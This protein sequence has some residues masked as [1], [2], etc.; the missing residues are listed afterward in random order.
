MQKNDNDIVDNAVAEAG[1]YDIIRKRLSEQGSTLKIQAQQLNAE[2]LEEFG[3]VQMEAVGRTRVRT[4]NNC[5]PRDIV[6]VGEQLL[7]GYNVF[8]GLKKDTQISDV[9]ALFSLSESDGKYELI[10]SDIHKSFL[11]DQRFKGDFDELYR[12]YKEARLVK[13]TNKDGKLLAG[14]QVGERQNDLKV[15]RWSISPDGGKLDYIDNRGERDIQLPDQYDFEWVETSREDFVHGKHPHVNIL[16]TVFVETIGGDLTIKVEDNTE[17][18]LGIYSEPVDEAN[19]SL[20]DASVKYAKVGHLI[21]LGITPYKE[22]NTRYFVFNSLSEKVD[23][24][25]AI[26]LSCIQ[27]PEDHG[28]IFPGGY[29]LESG[30]TKS[31]PGDIDGLRFK[32]MI[33][34]PNGEDVL[35]VFYEETEGK[36]AL[37]SYNLIT[38]SLQN[39]IFSNGYALYQNGTLIIFSSEEESTRV[40]PMQIWQTSY[41]SAEFASQQPEST[42]ELGKIGNSELVRGISD[43]YSIQQMIESTEISMRHYEELNETTKRIFDTHYWLEDERNTAIAGTLKEVSKTAELVIDEFEKVQ[44]IQQQSTQSLKD[45]KSQQRALLSRIA[46]T[47]WENAAEFVAAIAEIRKQR[48]HIATIKDFRYIDVEELAQLDQQ[49]VEAEQGLGDQTV[50]FLARE[51]SL[52][53]YSQSTDEYAELI[54][55]AQTNAEIRPIIASIDETTSQLDLLSE[56]VTT[57]KIDDTTLRTRIVDTISEV[58]AKLNQ[59]KARGSQKQKG[60]GSEEAVAQFSA[61][62]KL[63]SQSITNALG[64]ADTPEKLSLIHI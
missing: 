24:I 16:D 25:D 45:A 47:T 1:A 20:D 60:L 64:V 21:L 49:L 9:F 39:P 50:E 56:L 8:I 17:N 11:Y 15:F 53:S 4:E 26:G 7:F 10:E 37:F 43:L 58:Y 3:G 52:G 44:S 13:L 48:G 33:R 40:H 28:V 51:D 23:R 2:R 5:V 59:T 27:L 63:F 57:L 19:Q 35:Y 22:E 30:E 36:F 6:Q 31:F 34:S 14:F 29:Y 32:R 54:A 46:T 38:K 41:I 12:Y 62:F 61:Q 18:G 55:K 42:S